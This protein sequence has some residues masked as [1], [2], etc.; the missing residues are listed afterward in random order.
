MLFGVDRTVNG[1]IFQKYI[2]VVKF[3]KTSGLLVVLLVL[4]IA[5]HDIPSV[6]YSFYVVL[7]CF[8]SIYS[9]LVDIAGIIAHYRELFGN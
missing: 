5:F 4:I 9:L 1:S 3:T 2:K 8:K 7:N 6:I